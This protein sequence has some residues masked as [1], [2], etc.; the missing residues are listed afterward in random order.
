VTASAVRPT[1]R[2]GWLIAIVAGVAGGLVLGAASAAGQARMGTGGLA[3]WLE[4]VGGPWILV[5]FAVG[6]LSRR[7]LPG[8][9]AGV[10]AMVVA[11]AV[12][13]VTG[14]SLAAGIFLRPFWL[15]MGVSVGVVFGALGGWWGERPPYPWLPAGL[16]GGVI[17][18][19]VL[20]LS[21]GG[22]P[23]P[24]FSTSLAVTQAIVGLG[25]ASLLGW[26]KGWW[27]AATLAVAVACVIGFVEV[28]TGLPSQLV[29]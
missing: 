4:N 26:R 15:L 12:Y 3:F 2:G 22:L 20:A 9:L 28:T 16:A 23:H 17:A 21:V 8:C 19:E 18:G 11:L 6:A 25:G 10:V 1:V 29:W 14:G 7:R 27:R 13:D 5:A 24:M